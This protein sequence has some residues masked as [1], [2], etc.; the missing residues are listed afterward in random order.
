MPTT[1]NQISIYLVSVDSV[2]A[3]ELSVLY[4][5][6]KS[7][8][9]KLSKR[10]TSSAIKS[11]K[12][13]RALLLHILATDWSALGSS[14]EIDDSTIPPVLNGDTPPFLSIS[15]SGDYVAVVVSENPVAIDVEMA[16]R[17]R[18]YLGL[19]SRVFHLSEIKTIEQSKSKKEL[20]EAFYKI[21]TLRECF[22]KL[23]ILESL[24][25]QEFDSEV[26]LR[27]GEL[28]PFS[29]INNN[30]YLSLISTNSSKI[31]LL[32]FD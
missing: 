20:E 1:P 12:T 22:Y 32:R 19:A 24:M 28:T 3:E 2:F 30:L 5:L 25:D 14:Y 17:E 9:D 23:G 31:D 10:S 29:C 13:S 7:S 8:K 18:D 16:V 4:P 26:K 27:E 15:H 21:W 6:S 11:F